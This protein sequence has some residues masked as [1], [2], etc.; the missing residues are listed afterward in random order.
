MDFS[1]AADFHIQKAFECLTTFLQA[2]R[3]HYLGVN[4]IAKVQN[5]VFVRNTAEWSCEKQPVSINGRLLRF[6]FTDIILC[7]HAGLC[8]RLSTTKLSCY[9]TF[10][11][12][13]LCNQFMGKVFYPYIDHSKPKI[14]AAS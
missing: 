3:L 8:I 10:G 6:L 13:D 9:V 4:W 2:A 7:V 11:D 12:P 1:T 14:V 5:T